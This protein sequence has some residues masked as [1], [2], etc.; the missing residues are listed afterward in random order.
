MYTTEAYSFCQTRDSS[1][2][3]LELEIPR[4]DVTA[5]LSSDGIGQGWQSKGMKGGF[6]AGKGVVIGAGT[7]LWQCSNSETEYSVR[8]TSPL[9]G[10]DRGMTDY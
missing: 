6:L 5:D 7:P 9:L 8:V 10:S 1:N 3:V 4:A 2:L